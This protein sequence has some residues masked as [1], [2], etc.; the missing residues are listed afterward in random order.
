ML[1]EMFANDLHIRWSIDKG[2]HTLTAFDIWLASPERNQYLGGA[3]FRPSALPFEVL[4]RYGARIAKYGSECLPVPYVSPP[5]VMNFWNGF[6]V[7]PK[8]GSWKKLFDHIRYVVCD[9]DREAFVY[10]I[11][12]MAYAVQFP[13][14]QGET[15]IVLRGKEGTGKGIFARAFKDLFGGH[16]MQIV[17]PEHLTGL[18]SLSRLSPRAIRFPV[19]SAYDRLVSREQACA[20][21]SKATA[22]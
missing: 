13:H 20:T 22:V 4:A 5:D 10:V 12:W 9:G 1:K 6:G 17:Q 18:I 7:T 8:P 3:E 14:L 21:R 15:V 16:G 11:C 2:L 19:G